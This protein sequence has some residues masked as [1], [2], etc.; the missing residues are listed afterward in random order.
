LGFNAAR[1]GIYT[2]AGGGKPV[3]RALRSSLTNPIELFRNLMFESSFGNSFDI[4]MAEF[5][6]ILRQI[7]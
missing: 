3:G 6:A 7:P 1:S 5:T 4:K 2:A